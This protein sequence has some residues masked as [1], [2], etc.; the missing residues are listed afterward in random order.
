MSTPEKHEGDMLSSQFSLPLLP[1]L[2]EPARRPTVLSRPLALQRTGNQVGHH[3]QL[4]LACEECAL[5]ACLSSE[6]ARVD[7]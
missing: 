2:A 3:C 7:S 6:G 4:L 5:Y 1:S